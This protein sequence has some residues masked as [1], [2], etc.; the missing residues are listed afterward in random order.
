MDDLKPHHIWHEERRAS[1][2]PVQYPAFKPEAFS[3]WRLVGSR[4]FPVGPVPKPSPFAV[5]P[6]RFKTATGP[7]TVN[8]KSPD[9]PEDVDITTYFSALRIV[10]PGDNVEEGIDHG[11]TFVA[12]DKKYPGLIKQ[13]SQGGDVIFTIPLID[14]K[15]V[16]DNAVD[17]T[18]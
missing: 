9:I 7:T 11:S 6:L 4:W 1:I 13:G 16:E 14:L 15:I 2:M 5:L 8:P 10:F 12:L 18:P 17:I 3:T